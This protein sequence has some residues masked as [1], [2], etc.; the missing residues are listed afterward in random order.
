M[1]EHHYVP[2]FYLR[3][4]LDPASVGTR[5]PWLWVAKLETRKVSRRSPHNVAKRASYYSIP[6]QRSAVETEAVERLFSQMEDAAAPIVRKLNGGAEMLGGQEWADLRYFAAF[7]A[8][9]TPAVRTQFE[10]FL[11]D[12]ADMM[13][14]TSAS[15]PAHFTEMWQKAHPDRTDTPEEIERMRQRLLESD[16]KIRARPILSLKAA[17]DGVNSAVYPAF[18]RMRW[19]ILRSSTPDTYFLTSD[20]PVSWVDPTPR[21]AFYAGHGLAM[22][23]AEVSFPVGPRVCLFAGWKLAPEMDTLRVEPRLV[24]QLNTRRVIFSAGQVYAHQEALARW[25]VDLSKRHRAPGDGP[26]P[27]S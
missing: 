8:L 19:V 17:F 27:E 16:F 11:G 25:A 18:T 12:V 9:R 13:L 7:L 22:A 10:Q 4:F 14:K 15:H 26:A 20:T 3:E 2:Q 5:S 21:P 24:E 1:A 6:G 23:N